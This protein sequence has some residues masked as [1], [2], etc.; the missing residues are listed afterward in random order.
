MTQSAPKKHSWKRLL[1]APAHPLHTPLPEPQSPHPHPPPLPKA[2]I[3]RLWAQL[4]RQWD[5]AHTALKTNPAAA[6]DLIALVE[7]MVEQIQGNLGLGSDV[8]DERPNYTNPLDELDACNT[9]SPLMRQGA[10]LLAEMN[11]LIPSSPKLM[12]ENF[13]PQLVRPRVV[14]E[15]RSTSV[16]HS[17]RRKKHKSSR[18]APQNLDPV[19]AQ[20]E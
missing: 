6:P 8:I 3:L 17:N 18:P 10:E 7:T 14:A 5:E 9:L 13:P 20:H 15:G 11:T 1:P 2:H 12:D 16:G 4:R 19:L